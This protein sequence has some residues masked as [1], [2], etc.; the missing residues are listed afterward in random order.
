MS[1]AN[2]V[3]INRAVIAADSPLRLTPGQ[4]KDPIRVLADFFGGFDLEDTRDLMWFLV[5]RVVCLGDEDLDEVSRS[6]IL[7]Y[8]EE[9]ERL[10]E[11]AYLIRQKK[12]H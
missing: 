10:I 12:G 9:V 6:D 11:A 8:Y 7:M 1:D 3:V 5:S 4:M 2:R